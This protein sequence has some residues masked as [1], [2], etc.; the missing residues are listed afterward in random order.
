MKQIDAWAI[1]PG[2][3]GWKLG[4]EMTSIYYLK[5]IRN[6][7]KEYLELGGDEWVSFL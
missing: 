2:F 6:E 1:I 4:Q 5:V 7:L 3:H